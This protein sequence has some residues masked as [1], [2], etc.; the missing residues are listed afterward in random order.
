MPAGS[1]LNSGYLPTLPPPAY[2]VSVWHTA[3]RFRVPS[4]LA[5]DMQYLRQLLASAV[6]N[7][8][9]LQP[10]SLLI[11]RSPYM[12]SPT[13]TLYEGLG[14]WCSAF[15]FKWRLSSTKPRLPWLDSTYR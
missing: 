15:D 1:S 11:P 7:T 13:N 12:I 6:A 2:T 10:I 3:K 5:S 4:H 14:G 9:W 8:I